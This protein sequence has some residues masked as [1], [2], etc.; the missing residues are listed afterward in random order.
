MSF[1]TLFNIFLESNTSTLSIFRFL[2]RSRTPFSIAGMFSYCFRDKNPSAAASPNCLFWHLTLID[3]GPVMWLKTVTHTHTR[4]PPPHNTLR[5]HEKHQNSQQ[6]ACHIIQHDTCETVLTTTM[7]QALWWQNAAVFI[8]I[9]WPPVHLAITCTLRVCG[10]FEVIEGAEIMPCPG[11]H[12]HR[13]TGAG[14]TGST[15][16]R[17][18]DKIRWFDQEQQTAMKWWA[19]SCSGRFSSPPPI[20]FFDSKGAAEIFELKVFVLEPCFVEMWKLI[21]NLIDCIAPATSRK[22]RENASLLTVISHEHKGTEIQSRPASTHT[23]PHTQNHTCTFH[24]SSLA[25]ATDLHIDLPLPTPAPT[26]S[27]SVNYKWKVTK[28]GCQ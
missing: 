1:F 12:T 25:A 20:S 11:E 13:N 26:L 19:R 15:C 6:I 5:G 28:G 22:C 23:C 10:R 14:H 24:V 4:T 27:H 7:D 18:M 2:Q 3:G 16:L 17:H 8:Y 9:G 21:H